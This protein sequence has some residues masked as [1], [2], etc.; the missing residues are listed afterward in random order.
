MIEAK[1]KGAEGD[2][3]ALWLA[4]KGYTETVVTVPPNLMRREY[5]LKAALAAATSEQGKMAVLR[6]F[7]ECFRALKSPAT[8]ADLMESVKNQF[9]PAAVGDIGWL[10]T[11]LRREDADLKLADAQAQATVELAQKELLLKSC[12]SPAW[13]RPPGT[14]RTRDA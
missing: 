14:P 8:A 6:E 1:I 4:A 5:W 7:A 3:K 9:S 10:Q 13:P 12:Q 2:S 11:Q